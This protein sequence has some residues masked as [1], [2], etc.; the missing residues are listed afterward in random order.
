MSDPRRTHTAPA[1]GPAA[2][3]LSVREAVDRVLAYVPD[4]LPL[5]A[6]GAAGVA[7]LLPSRGLAT[8]VDLLLAALVL[9]TALDIDPRQLLAV[10]ARGRMIVLLAVVPML[11]LAVGAW[12]LGHLVHGSTRDGLLAL[13]VSPTEVAAVGLIGLIGGPAE[14]AI[15]VLA[16]SLLLSAVLG[17]PLLALLASGAHA[18]HVVP[19]LGRFA[20][21]V[22]VPL[23]AGLLVRAARPTLAT[24]EVEL[25]ASASVIVAVLIY[26]SL[27]DDRGGGSLTG[28]VAVSVAF[29]AL[30]V[31]LA[32]GGMPVLRAKGD[33]SI[34][35]AIGMRDFAVAAALAA[36]AFGSAAAR[37]AGIYG[38]LMLLAG[39]T[40]TGVTRRVARR[41]RSHSE[42]STPSITPATD[43][44]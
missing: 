40:I 22:G 36:S 7:W 9:V 21:V 2:D 27:S 34:A 43:P 16:A 24:R 32:L 6:L 33:R 17:P 29:L 37:V 20:L 25:S 19:L 15:A 30:S 11:A 14:L 1:A 41:S 23:L 28:A 42:A 4:A 44:Q 39:A 18:A 35:L 26:A 8:H 3:R 38:V 12:G 13:G 5:L 31:L 10:R